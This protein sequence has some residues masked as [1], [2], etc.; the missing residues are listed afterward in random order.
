M[1]L[2]NTTSGTN[3]HTPFI[4]LPAGKNLMVRVKVWDQYGADSGWSPYKWLYINRP[5]IAA[6]TWKVNPPVAV[7]EGPA[8]EGDHIQLINQSTDPDIHTITSNWSIRN[9]SGQTSSYTEDPFLTFVQ[10]GNYEVTLT[11]TDIYGVS[12]SL[13]RIIGVSEMVILGYVNHTDD[14]NANRKRYNQSKTRT[15]ESPRGYEV[16]FPGERFLLKAA[17]LGN[18]IRTTSQILGTSFDTE[19]NKA[20][21]GTFDGIWTGELWDETM[22]RW[23]NQNVTFRFTVHTPT[24]YTKIADVQ[25]TIDDDGYWRQHRSR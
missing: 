3:T 19:M 21:G 1:M 25:V 7:F 13:T 24:G 14:W 6:F 17:T 4:D 11:V 15:D 8:W 9:P 10:P 16:F 2:Q 22:L 20:S 18:V 23:D 12:S 5:P